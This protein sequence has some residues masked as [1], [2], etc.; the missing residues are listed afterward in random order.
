M[1]LITKSDN[2]VALKSELFITNMITD[3]IRQHKV[4]LPINHKSLYFQRRIAKLRKKEKIC[5]KRL[6]KEA[7]KLFRCLLVDLNYDF[8]CEWLIELSNNKLSYT[9]LAGE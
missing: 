4:L 6:T 7:F 9:N 3:R 1:Q 8:E 2:H 5:I